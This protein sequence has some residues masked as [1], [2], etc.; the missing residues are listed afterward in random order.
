MMM[1]G[2][3]LALLD[4][5]AALTG[6]DVPEADQVRQLYEHD[7]RLRVPGKIRSYTQQGVQEIEL[8]RL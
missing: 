4:R 2:D 1:T 7:D 5:I 8:V 3:D 6:D